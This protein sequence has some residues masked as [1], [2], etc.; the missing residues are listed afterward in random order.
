MKRR[1]ACNKE[2]QLKLSFGMIFSIILIIIFL[3]FAFF[4]IKTFIGVQDTASAGKFV[5]DLQNDID[6]IWKSAQSSQ[7][8]SYSLPSGTEMVCFVDFLVVA[9]G[10]NSAIYNEL[11]KSYYG[12]ENMVFY[13]RTVQPDSAKIEN[14]DIAEITKNSNPFCLD[15]VQG[16][17]SLRLSKDFNDALVKITK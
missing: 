1:G 14:I 2:G 5:N 11:K 8:E 15:S 10:E 17:V 12:S 3:T 6:I 16:K 9:N 4:A 13:P 7:Q